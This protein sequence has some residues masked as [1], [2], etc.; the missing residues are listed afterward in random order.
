MLIFLL[1]SQRVFLSRSNL[2]GDLGNAFRVLNDGLR[3]WFNDGLRKLVLND[4]LRR[5]FDDGF[6]KLVW[7]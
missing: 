5:W 4:G 7:K 6:R 3:R 2:F 1:E